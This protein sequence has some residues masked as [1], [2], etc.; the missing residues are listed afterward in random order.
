MAEENGTDNTNATDNTGGGGGDGGKW[1]DSIADAG[2]KGNE[3]IT[4]HNGVES[5]AKS[6]VEKS[7][8]IAELETAHQVPDSPE[9]YGLPTKMEGYTEDELKAYIKEFGEDAKAAGLSKDSAGKLFGILAKRE[10]EQVSANAKALEK[11]EADAVVA[12]KKEYGD[13]YEEV[14]GQAKQAVTTINPEFSKFAEGV[15]LFRSPHFVAFM[16]SITDKI[17]PDAIVQTRK[18]SGGAQKSDAEVLFGT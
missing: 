3:L 8:R 5:L 14:V 9:G 16:K 11:A 12:M 15:G 4:A 10:L 17:S 7:A 13:K 1:Y 18:L 2:L 6:F